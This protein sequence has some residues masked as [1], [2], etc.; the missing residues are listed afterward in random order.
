M[1]PGT[2]RIADRFARA[3]FHIHATRQAADP[4]EAVAAVFNVMRNLGVPR[5]ITTA[6]QPRISSTIWRTVADRKNRLY[7]FEDTF[8]PNLVWVRLDRID[9]KPGSGTRKL[10]PHGAPDLSGD[11]T[12]NFMSAEPFVFASQQ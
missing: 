4:R 1:L 8:G 2:H 11:Q 5:G 6:G 12:A 10:T 3:S 7:L 9:F